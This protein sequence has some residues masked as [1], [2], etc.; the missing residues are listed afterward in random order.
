MS[1][2]ANNVHLNATMLRISHW[3]DMTITYKII[4]IADILIFLLYWKVLL[5]SNTANTWTQMPSIFFCYLT[6]DLEIKIA[7][8]KFNFCYLFFFFF[9]CLPT[10]LNKCTTVLSLNVVLFLCKVFFFL[11]LHTTVTATNDFPSAS[12]FSIS[13]CNKNTEFNALNV[14]GLN[15][16]LPIHLMI[17]G[18]GINAQRSQ[19]EL[20]IQS[21]RK[22]KSFL[23][24]KNI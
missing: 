4:P 11:L 3:I 2:C 22:Y 20:S 13:I 10:E 6:V 16:L 14:L 7:I 21:S 23:D 1:R 24:W 19:T 9:V 18:C 5:C 15:I 8:I 17:V 12:A